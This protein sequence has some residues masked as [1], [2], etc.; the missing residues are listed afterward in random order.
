MRTISSSTTGPSRTGW[1]T[2]SCGTAISSGSPGGS[3]RNGRPSILGPRC[4]LGVGPELNANATIYK[5]GFAVTSP[6]VGNVRN[7]AT[8]EYLQETVAKLSRLLGAEYDVVAHDLH[9]QFLSTRFAKEIAEERGLGLVPVQHHR[10]HIAATTTEP[11][12]GIAIDGVGYGDDGTVWGGEVFAGQVPD[13]TRVAHLEPVA[14]PGG[15]LATRFPER[16]LYGILPDEECLA[17]LRRRGWS[18]VELGVIKKQVATKFNVTMTSSTG[19]VLDAASAL[20]GICRERTYDGEPAMKLEAAAVGGTAEAWEPVFS[21]VGGC[22]CLSTRAILK[23]ALS[24]FSRAPA[25]DK[26][27]VRDI[28]A[29]DPVQP[30]PGD[31]RPCHPRGRKRGH[32]PCRLKRGRRREPGDPGDHPCRS[33]RGRAHPCH[34]RCVPARGRV[35]LLW[36]VRLGRNAP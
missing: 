33:C 2:R 14:M 4:I 20:L 23:T 16:M 8:L 25:G 12:I 35:R 3:P 22:E 17:L 5:G 13:L 21:T 7:P 24:R 36:P 11:C 15:D 9:P 26:N 30:C 10:A 34:Q 29:S 19:R 1:T 32:F 31:R 18:D 28:A 6:H 27:A